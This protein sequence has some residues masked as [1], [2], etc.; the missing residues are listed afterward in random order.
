MARSVGP[1]EIASSAAPSV[2]DD[3][4]KSLTSF[5]SESYVHASQIAGEE[6]SGSGEGEAQKPKKS[7]AQLWNEMKI[8]C[9]W[10]RGIEIWSAVLTVDSDIES[11]YAAV[12]S[13]PSYDPYADTAQPTRSQKLPCQCRYARSG[14]PGVDDQLGE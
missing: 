11:V 9:R 7:K 1:S 5:Q 2:T 8:S 13:I 6:G 4:G 10:R 12:Y 14:D 3:D